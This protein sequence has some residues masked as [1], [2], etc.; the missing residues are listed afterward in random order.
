[1]QLKTL[2]GDAA[3]LDMTTMTSSSYTAQPPGGWEVFAVEQFYK[4]QYGPALKVVT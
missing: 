1:M 4:T 3:V 2:T